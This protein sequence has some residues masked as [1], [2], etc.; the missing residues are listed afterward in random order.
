MF[1]SC[2][3]HKLADP[4]G[5]AV[6]RSASFSLQPPALAFLQDSLST[7]IVKLAAHDVHLGRDGA[8]VVVRL[9][10]ADVA[11]TDDLS[12]LARYLMLVEHREV[13]RSAVVSDAG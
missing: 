2:H 13:E 3:R 6:P 9:L 7:H 8:E 1:L 4:E 11:G 5:D 10:I 12:D